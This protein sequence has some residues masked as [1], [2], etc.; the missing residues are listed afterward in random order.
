MLVSFLWSPNS[1]PADIGT[2]DACKFTAIHFKNVLTRDRIVLRFNHKQISKAAIWTW[3]FPVIWNKIIFQNPVARFADLVMWWFVV[4]N[5]NLRFK[6]SVR[7]IIYLFVRISK[8]P[9]N[10]RYPKARKLSESSSRKNFC[11]FEFRLTN[12][13]SR[14]FRNDLNCP[15][16]TILLRCYGELH[17]KYYIIMWFT[18]KWCPLF[19]MNVFIFTLYSKIKGLIRDSLTAIDSFNVLI[20]FFST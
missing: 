8:Q 16:V 15:I 1:D 13:N 7:V 14:I 9:R 6:L 5:L 10:F 20:S 17:I 12:S 4:E 11:I 2:K 3:G 18:L 19:L